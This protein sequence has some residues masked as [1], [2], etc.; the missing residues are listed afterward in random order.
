[1]LH[2]IQVVMASRI[3]NKREICD[4]SI[5]VNVMKR[6]TIIS[7]ILVLSQICSAATIHVRGDSATIQAGIDG[8]SEGDTVLVASGYYTG[9]GNRDI[10]FNGKNIVVISENGPEYTILDLQGSPSSPH[11]AFNF[12]NNE[13]SSAELIGFTIKNGYGPYLHQNEGGALRIAYS[14]APTIKSCIFANNEGGNVGGAAYCSSSAPTFINCTFVGNDANSGGGVHSRNSDVVL[15]NCV[16]AFGSRGSAVYCNGGSMELYCCDLYGNDGGDW[17]NCIQDQ[18]GINGNITEDPLF[19]D[20][21]SGDYLVSSNSPCAPINNSCSVLIGAMNSYCA[22]YIDFPYAAYLNF[23]SS[24]LNHIVYFPEPE[25]FWSYIDTASTTQVQYEIQVSDDDDWSYAEMWYSGVVSSSDTMVVYAGAPLTPGETYYIRVR[26]NNGSDWG[27]WAESWFTYSSSFVIRIPGLAPTIQAGIDLASNGDTVLV[28]TGT[29]S[30]LGNR[31]ITYDG[32]NIVV[33]SEFGPEFTIIDCEGS[34]SEPHR[35]LTLTDG[36]DISSILEG[37][38]ITDGYGP[39][40]DGSHVGGGVY[41]KNSSLSILNCV[42]L[43]NEAEIGGAIFLDT[44]T[45]VF[46]KNCDILYNQSLIGAGIYTILGSYLSMENSII[47]FNKTGE[48]VY[49]EIQGSP[50]IACSD[51]VYNEGG[52]WTGCIY[53]LL[54]SNN[55][56]SAHPEFCDLANDDFSLKTNSPCLPAGNDC[57]VFIGAYKIGCTGYLCGDSNTD[58]AV[59]VSDAVWIIG[60]VF[61]GADAPRPYLSGDANCD[62]LVN[63]SDAVWIINYVFIGGNAPCDFDGDGIP[64]C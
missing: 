59:N 28:A 48:A 27:S 20:T 34:L 38:T 10:S 31:D 64:D 53:S 47:A 6:W 26:I 32:K 3:A 62:Y 5:G 56:F 21:A 46:I 23:G 50:Y 52:D 16:I 4:I 25:I 33:L 17:V 42:L 58:H 19:C 18:L 43:E 15:E 63:V 9:V 29:Y 14:A 7:F 24:A 30:G 45:N 36:E 57:N 51:I 39:E 1:M 22:G 41:L 2:A 8:A 55:N 11:R 37:F 44:S 40:V 60:Y 61:V 35:A 49:C 12:T 54:D 13:T